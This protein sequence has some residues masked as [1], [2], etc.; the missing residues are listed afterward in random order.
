MHVCFHWP[1][2]WFLRVTRFLRKQQF[3]YASCLLFHMYMLGT[4]PLLYHQLCLISSPWTSRLIRAE[5]LFYF[6]FSL[7]IFFFL[8]FYEQQITPSS[9]SQLIV[10]PFLSLTSIRHTSLFVNTGNIFTASSPPHEHR[11]SFPSLPL[12]PRKKEV[13]HANHRAQCRC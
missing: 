7:Y 4:L 8:F 6:F 2:N 5:V 10:C 11:N 12:G 9:S 3:C 13:V 1:T